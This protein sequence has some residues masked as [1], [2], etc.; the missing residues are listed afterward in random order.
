MSPTLAGRFLT[1]GSSRKLSSWFILYVTVFMPSTPPL[2]H[3]SP[4][5]S[6]SACFIRSCCGLVSAASPAHPSSH[7]QR[8]PHISFLTFAQAVLSTWKDLLPF[9][10]CLLGSLYTLKP[11]FRE[12]NGNPLL[13]SCRLEFLLTSQSLTA[14]P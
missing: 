6:P 14:S 5:S 2:G 13:Y 3:P 1:P 4:L 8:C 11:C 9:F 10:F 7:T 12:G